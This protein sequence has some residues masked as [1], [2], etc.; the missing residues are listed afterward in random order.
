MTYSENWNLICKLYRYF[1]AENSER[2]VICE[3]KRQ[4]KMHEN[5]IQPPLSKSLISINSLST[6]MKGTKSAEENKM[7]W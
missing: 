7:R 3:K 1:T 2:A 5:R 6:P 4:T